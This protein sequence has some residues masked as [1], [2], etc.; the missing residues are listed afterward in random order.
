VDIVSLDGNINRRMKFDSGNFPAF[1]LTLGPDVIDVIIF[2]GTK[3]CAYTSANT[4]LFAIENLVISN[5]M[6]TYRFL[7]PVIS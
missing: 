2:D 6:R 4:G 1:K 3:N 5:H 7:V